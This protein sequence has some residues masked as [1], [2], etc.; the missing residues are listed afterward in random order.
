MVRHTRFLITVKNE[1]LQKVAETYPQK[2]YQIKNELVM[3]Q[4]FLFLDQSVKI[5][6]TPFRVPVY[7]LK[8]SNQTNTIHCDV[9]GT[10][11]STL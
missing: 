2:A 11:L 1:K 10:L 8:Y 5:D 7:L 4:T 9:S 6:E 3:R